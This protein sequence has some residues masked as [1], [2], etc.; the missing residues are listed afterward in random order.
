MASPFFVAEAAMG[1]SPF[2]E[3]LYA[4]VKRQV[5]RVARIRSRVHSPAKGLALRNA[6]NSVA[7][8]S[9]VPE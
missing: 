9:K 1:L 8:C 7:D 4:V 3:P 5:A 6:V 2:E